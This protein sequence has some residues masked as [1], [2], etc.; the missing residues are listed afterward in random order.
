LTYLRSHELRST[1]E[2]AG[3]T[4]IPHVLLAETVV[5][6]LNVAIQSEKNV[7][8]LQVTVDD[9]VLVEIFE[10]QTDFRGVEPING[11]API[12]LTKN[13]TGNV[14]C[15][16]QTKLASL[17]VQHQIT[18]TDVL[19]DKVHTGLCLETGVKVQQEGVA[20]L[21]GNQED[22]LLRLGAL[23]FVILDNEF[24]LQHFDGIELLGALR[25]RQHDLTEVTLTKH[26]KEVEV[27]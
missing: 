26:S 25:L 24:L 10:S 3:G 14:L 22:A 19:H 6:N 4:A 11:L 16:L 15:A 1:T 20:F 12:I 7:I 27:I 13:C 9:T 5:C 17:N 21:V 18:T 8:Q 23:H 2:R